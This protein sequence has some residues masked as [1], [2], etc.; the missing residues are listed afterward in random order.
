MLV[1]KLEP[2]HIH[3]QALGIMRISRTVQWFSEAARHDSTGLQRIVDE[4]ALSTIYLASF[5]RW[6][7]DDSANNRKSKDFLNT[8][9]RRWLRICCN[10][11]KRII[12]P[13]DTEEAQQQPSH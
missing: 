2:G 13:A 10:R 8:A 4:C 11:S 7:F 6:L 3:L 5:A 1:Y 9:L 12:E